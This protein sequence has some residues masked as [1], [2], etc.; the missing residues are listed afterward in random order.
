MHDRAAAPEV[1][2]EERVASARPSPFGL[3]ERHR[4]WIAGYLFVLPQ[5]FGFAIFAL[6]PLVAVAWYSLNDWN[7]LAGTFTFAG[8]QNY[9]DLLGDAEFIGSLRTT[10]AFSAGLVI[11]NLSLALA[12]AVLVNQK[13]RF[14]GLFRAAFF[15]PVVVSVV[16]WTI[17]WKFLL[18]ANGGVNGLLLLA[19]IHGP[20]W[21][22]E[23]VAALFSVIVVQVFKNVGL[24]MILFLAA[25]QG[26]PADLYEAAHLD[27]ARALPT[28]WRITLPLLTPTVLLTSILTVIGSLQVFSQIQVLTGG[29]P[30][31]STTVIAYYLYKQA[32]AYNHFGYA[33]A[34]AVVLFAVVLGLTVLQWT[35]RRRWVF[36]EN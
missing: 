19:G 18:Q 30:G 11:F 9:R 32:F 1:G 5:I 22:R 12:L 8:I 23:P 31:S 24:N 25:L 20:N 17:V 35:L 7:V 26:V 36:Y 15:S 6:I 34:I 4:D 3:S 27:G 2:P 10:A 16:A 33:S 13:L 21:L 14:G 29:G 28:F